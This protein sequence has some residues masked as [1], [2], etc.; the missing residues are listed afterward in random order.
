MPSHQPG[1]LS[2]IFQGTFQFQS[3]RGGHTTCGYLDLGVRGSPD[4]TRCLYAYLEG[5]KCNEQWE[6][7]GNHKT[8]NNTQCYASNPFYIVR[9]GSTEGVQHLG[10]I[11]KQL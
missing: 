2:F 4:S 1:Y 10:R 9:L 3:K 6:G 5:K 7:L 8:Q 11:S